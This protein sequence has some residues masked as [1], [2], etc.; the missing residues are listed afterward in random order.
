M[1]SPVVV[2][3]VSPAVVG[4]GARVWWRWRRWAR[5]VEIKIL[6]ISLAAPSPVTGTPAAHRHRHA[7]G[8]DRPRAAPSGPPPLCRRGMRAGRA[9]V[10]GTSPRGIATRRR[11]AVERAA[12]RHGR[13]EAACQ[14]ARPVESALSRYQCHGE[15]VMA[16]LVNNFHGRAST[17]LI[18]RPLECGLR[19][20][21]RGDG[22]V[23]KTRAGG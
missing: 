13:A 7:R 21:L 10:R 18:D 12:A 23:A 5:A 6:E 22:P 16:L 1:L 20:A 3:V 15:V 2:A 8:R 4:H 11:L 9:H 14:G 19:A 17:P